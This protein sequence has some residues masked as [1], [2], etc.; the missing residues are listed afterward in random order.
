M[1]QRSKPAHSSSLPQQDG[2]SQRTASPNAKAEWRKVLTGPP[3]PSISNTAAPAESSRPLQT[4]L[5]INNAD[6][7]EYHWQ[8]PTPEGFVLNEAALGGKSLPP[9][10]KMADAHAPDRAS[11]LDE[12]NKAFLATRPAPSHQRGL[13]WP[14]IWFLLLVLVIASSGGLGGAYAYRTWY[15]PKSNAEAGPASSQERAVATNRAIA[16]STDKLVSSNTSVIAQAVVKPLRS[17]TLSMSVDGR[18]HDILVREG[19]MVVAGQPLVRLDDTRQVV[20]IAQAGAAVQQAEA[21]RQELEAGARSEEIAAAQAV[22]DAAQARL[23]IL[24]QD[25]VPAADENAAAAAVIAAQAKLDN[26]YGGPSQEALIAARAEMQ[27]AE[28]ALSTA[29]SAYNAVRWRNDIG[30]LPESTQLQQATITYE[31][32]KA[33][34]DELS[35]GPNNAEISA[36]LAEIESARATLARAQ[37]PAQ[38]GE[39]DA[40][41]AELRQAQAQLDLLRA[42]TRSERIAAAAAAVTVAQATLMDAQI[43]LADTVLSA[44]FGGVIANLDIEV[45]EQVG[46]GVPVV[47]LGD[48]STWHL[49]T[50]DLVEMDVVRVQPG[51]PVAITVDAL[52]DL[53]IFGTVAR[54]KSIGEDKLGDMTYTVYVNLNK[55]T[56]ELAWNMTATVYIGQRR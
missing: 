19:D 24:L 31:A 52:P 41:R 9:Q 44:P 56:N 15:A 34:Y 38:A 21:Q 4:V 27:K 7:V 29:R 28:A 43:A 54:V 42:G 3:T 53:E 11:Q 6:R 47:E 5:P 35:A 33:Q 46:A 22:V 25:T 1:S 23:D 2:P 13:T 8:I 49:E 45:G 17:A 36:A 39:I 40:A 37:T 55:P 32:A 51:A 48:L 18:V 12:Y 30:M 26:L 50:D 10:F 20:A 16:S 14:N